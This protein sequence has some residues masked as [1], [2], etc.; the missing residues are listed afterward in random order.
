MQ[1]P[2]KLRQKDIESLDVGM[3]DD[4][5]RAA[6]EDDVSFESIEKQYGLTESQVIAIMKFYTTDKMF[7]VWRTRVEG[8]PEKY[9]LKTKLEEQFLGEDLLS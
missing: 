5:I 4:I 8:R 3:R 7:A 9:A 1:L 2:S 6:W